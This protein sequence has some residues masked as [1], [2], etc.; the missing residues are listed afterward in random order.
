MRHQRWLERLGLGRPELRAWAL[1]DWGNSAFVTTILSAVFPIYFA[2]VA[3]GDLPR[4]EAT[5]RFSTTT[6]LALA[7]SA[8]VSPLLGALADRRGHRIPLLRASTL[9]GVA[10]SAALALVGRGHWPWAAVL[11]ALANIALS[12]SFVFYDSL[13]P[14]IASE[15]E[16]DRVSGAGYALGYVGGGILLAFNLAWI[17]APQSFGLPDSQVAARLSFLSA[18][19]WWALFAIP[20]LRRRT[21]GATAPRARPGGGVVRVVWVGLMATLRDLRRHRQASLMLVA[22]L[23]YSDGIGTVIRMATIYGAEI[24]IDRSA[25]IAALLVTQFVGIPF[26]FLFGSLGHR[27]GARRAIFLGLGVYCVITGLAF[28][29]RTAA[30]FFALAILVGTVQGGTQALSRSLFSR[31]I[32]QD[33]TGEFFGFFSIAD[34]FAGILGPAVFAATAAA[35]GSSR[36]AVAAVATFFVLGGVVLSFV[37]VDARS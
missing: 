8:I 4:V 12:A 10:A 25:M 21:L 20:L 11:F 24:G 7:V 33:R 27:I 13:L 29:M 17:A 14:A 19:L 37:D 32:P 28:F 9:V 16:V 34:K 22:F 5:I 18:A 15:Q 2:E 6:T 35:T 23:I 36:G 30:H 26:T 31:L 1:Y 3:A